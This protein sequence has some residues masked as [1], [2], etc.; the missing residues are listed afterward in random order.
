M[1]RKATKK[2][3]AP[4]AP[5]MVRTVVRTTLTFDQ[6]ISH[7][8]EYDAAISF[9]NN[10]AQEMMY[11]APVFVQNIKSKTVLKNETIKLPVE[12]NV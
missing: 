2:Q 11:N 4:A 3:A 12:E 9:A 5:S 1:A 8:D 7:P 6:V 10:E